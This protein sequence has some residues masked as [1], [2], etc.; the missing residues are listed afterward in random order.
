MLPAPISPAVGKKCNVGQMGFSLKEKGRNKMA[1]HFAAGD[2]GQP[3]ADWSDP[4]LS[5]GQD[6]L[7]HS[8]TRSRR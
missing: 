2:L 6:P 7:F 1:E 4:V 5:L 3:G 8:P